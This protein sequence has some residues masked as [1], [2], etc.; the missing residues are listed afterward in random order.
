MSEHLQVNGRGLF[1]GAGMLEAAFSAAS[2]L[3]SDGQ[4]SN[5]LLSGIILL[6]PIILPAAVRKFLVY[7]LPESH[8]EG[9][10]FLLANLQSYS[11]KLCILLCSITAKKC[12]MFY[13]NKLQVSSKITVF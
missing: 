5:P 2:S 7:L 8:Y 12:L 11:A 6:S 13:Y 4:P 10:C 3:I 1:P 9:I